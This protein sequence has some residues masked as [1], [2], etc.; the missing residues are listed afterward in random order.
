MNFIL[1]LLAGVIGAVAGFF[2]GV[3]IG[4]LLVP[5]FNI[6][7]FEGGAGYFVVF[8]GLLV[9]LLGLIVGI[10]LVLRYKGGHR[11]LGA[12][13]GRGALVLGA[14]AAI[15]VIG[16]QIRLATM[17]NFSGGNINPQMHF[18]IR[19]PAGMAEPQRRQIDFEMQAGS[20]R[21]GGQLKDDWLR[22]D[23]DRPVLSGFVPLYTRTSQRILVVTL[24]GQPKL[25]F[26]IGLSATPKS[27]DQFGAWQRVNFVDDGKPDS[28]PR[29]PNEAENFEIRFH[30]PEW[31][32]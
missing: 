10:V 11:K 4:S 13:A 14:I 26:S 6:S 31:R 32:Q 22:R 19:L 28:Q 5:V 30:V 27:S 9:G 20:Q 16:I 21:S 23:G 7:S 8:I 18:E 17:E 24:P 25:L 2:L 1:A 15:V 3:G 29:R 12:L